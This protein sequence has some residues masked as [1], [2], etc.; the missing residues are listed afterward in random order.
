VDVNMINGIKRS[1]LPGTSKFWIAQYLRP[2]ANG[3]QKIDVEAI[4]QAEGQEGLSKLLN[5]LN[6]NSYRFLHLNLDQKRDLY[7]QIKQISEKG[8]AKNDKDASFY[9]GAVYT[10]A[11]IE[12]GSLAAE[13]AVGGL[14]VAAIYGGGRQILKLGV[15]AA[16]KKGVKEL[17]KNAAIKTAAR[18]GGKKAAHVAGSRA[19]RVAA[20]EAGKSAAEM[21]IA[22]GGLG[23]V[24]AVGAQR[25]VSNPNIASQ[26]HMFLIE[27]RIIGEELGVVLANALRMG[28]GNIVQLYYQCAY[29]SS[30]M[31]NAVN[32]AQEQRAEA[33]L[34][35]T[36]TAPGL[37]PQLKMALEVALRNQKVKQAAG[38]AAVGAGRAAVTAAKDPRARVG[39]LSAILGYLFYRHN[40]AKPVK[41]NTQ[42]TAQGSQE[43]QTPPQRT[44]P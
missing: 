33:V 2:A 42:V 17:G 12:Y 29:Y 22:A 4:Y 5:G 9:Q 11:V 15:K 7:R 8:V 26:M 6:A 25:L 35:G 13:L 43:Q 34:R 39:V 1:S 23:G 20:G 36:A 31:V 41:P 44:T 18:T 16:L 38:N 10:C 19:T 3:K 32:P 21:A 27:Y 30:I 14:G 40:T 24:A 28:R 37:L